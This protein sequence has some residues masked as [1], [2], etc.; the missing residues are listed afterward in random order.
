MATRKNGNGNGHKSE[1]GK[2]TQEITELELFAENEGK[3]AGSRH[4]Q[5]DV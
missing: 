2:W 4:R 1:L 5:V 3:L